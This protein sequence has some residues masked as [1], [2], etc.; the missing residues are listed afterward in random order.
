MQLDFTPHS[1]P[2]AYDTHGT[3]RVAGTRVT[4]DTIVGYFKQ[5]KSPEELAYS[6]PT[7]GLSTIYATIAYYLRHE[8][9]VDAYLEQQGRE[10]DAIRSIIEAH[11][12]PQPTRN[13][14][15]ARRTQRE[16]AR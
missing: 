16:R 7:L 9:E 10:S 2:L 11:Q 8:I 14:L 12:G 5:G 3:V 1:I 13:Q 4:L 15:L 6:F